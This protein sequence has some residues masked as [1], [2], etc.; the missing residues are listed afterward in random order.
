MLV[1]RDEPPA[2]AAGGTPRQTASPRRPASTRQTASPTSLWRGQHLSTTLGVF[3]LAFMVAF[4]ALAVITVMPAVAEDLDGLTLYA[5]AFAAPLAVGIVARTASAPWID[6]VG[7]APALGWGVAVFV[8]GLVVCG[9]APS[10]GWFVVGRAVQGV[11]MGAVGVALYVVVAQAYPDALRPRALT[12]MT[13]AWMLPAVAGPPLAGWLEHAVGWRWVFLA[14]PALAALSMVAVWR[15]AAALRPAARVHDAAGR[16]GALLAAAAATA[17]VLGI[18]VAGQRSVAGWAWLLAGSLVVLVLSTRRLLPRGT[19]VAR[20][21]LPSLLAAR[22]L[23]AAAYFGAEVYVPLSLVETRDYP[24]A[25][26]GSTLT[27]AAC[28]WF[29]GSWSVAHPE[30]LGSLMATPLRRAG[31]G[32]VAVAVGVSAG[33][34]V[35]LGAPV[36]VVVV[37]WAV[38]GFGM[39]ATMSAIVAEVLRRAAPGR[40]GADSAALQSSDAI[41]ESTVLSLGAVL[42]ALALTSGVELALGVG[43]VLPVVS[44]LLGVGVLRRGFGTAAQESARGAGT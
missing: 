25:L 11:G 14:A 1:N 17:A 26:A 10:M 20:R 8:A 15:P 29:V 3:S 19:L 4:E 7:P 24:V 28:A 21:G 42:F 32:A 12:V 13:S 38:G 41:A 23:V 39:G 40:E 30:R 33:P 35:L 5:V 18:S 34:L 31:V 44:V 16:D 2:S 43:F 27:L 6:R 36:A 22:S 9:V 37:L